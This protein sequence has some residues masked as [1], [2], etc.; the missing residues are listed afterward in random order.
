MKGKEWKEGEPKSRTKKGDGGDG[1]FWY[2]SRAAGVKRSTMLTSSW[3]CSYHTSVEHSKSTDWRKSCVGI[4]WGE[5]CINVHFTVFKM[6][7]TDFWNIS[8]WKENNNKK[9]N[10]QQYSGSIK[11]AVC[12]FLKPSN[13]RKGKFND[14]ESSFLSRINY[15]YMQINQ[16]YGEMSKTKPWFYYITVK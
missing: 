5:F 7:F 3:S 2:A 6:H 10:Q 11:G 14:T 16:I 1:S 12:H 4:F 8:L 9:K 13:G 15:L